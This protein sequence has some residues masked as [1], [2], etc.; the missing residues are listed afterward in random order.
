MMKKQ[1]ISGL[2]V[3]VIASP[4][5]ADEIQAKYLEDG[6]KDCAGIHAEA[7]RNT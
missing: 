6:R 1:L 3:F 4:V 5:L 2:M 7:G